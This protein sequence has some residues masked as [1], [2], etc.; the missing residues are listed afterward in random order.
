M[1][2]E[3]A[4]LREIR[5]EHLLSSLENSVRLQESHVPSVSKTLA[6]FKLALQPNIP[7]LIK[8]LRGQFPN[9]TRP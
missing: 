5:G 6:E 8:T 3:L 2:S 7:S 9:L 4:R 1:E